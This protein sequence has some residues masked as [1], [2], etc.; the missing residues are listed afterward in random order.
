MHTDP[1]LTEHAN[2][3][4]NWARLYL[5]LAAIL[6]IGGGAATLWLARSEDARMRS[7]LLVQARLVADTLNPWRIINL[8]ASPSDLDSP[9]YQRIKSQLELMRSANSRFRFPYLT[10]L[11]PDGSVVF[12]ADSEPI[13]SLDHSPP[14]QVYEEV[15]TIFREVF[16]TG[17]A[18]VEGPVLDRWGNW[19]SA[20]I[21]IKPAEGAMTL[22]VLGI[23]MDAG[24]WSRDIFAHCL[25]NV[26][27]CVL[28]LAGLFFMAVLY[29][30]SETGRVSE[31]QRLGAG[32]YLRKP[33]TLEK[34]GAV[35]KLELQ[36][37]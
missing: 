2:V 24:N 37:T 9:D 35:V 25:P 36:R 11:S 34:L 12:L 18:T 29:R 1:L 3:G 19:I 31:A 17:T 5:L 20:L 13:E 4:F 15:S 23:D 28:G 16:I 10:R 14:G 26:A 22:A 27:L 6:L 7:A 33:Y 21:P 32:I 8:T 30:R